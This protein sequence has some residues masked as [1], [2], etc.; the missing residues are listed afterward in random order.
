ML[1]VRT[2]FD[3]VLDPSQTALDRLREAEWLNLFR[4]IE[5]VD[6]EGVDCTPRVEETPQFSTGVLR[7]AQERGAD[8]IVAQAPDGRSSW[9]PDRRP[10]Q[11]GL[12]LRTQAPL[13]LLRFPQPRK[14]LGRRIQDLLTGPD[15]T[16]G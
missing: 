6:L 4:L 16:F 3:W 13:L 9:F 2:W 7:V 14:T 12:I 15:V 8:L 1:A 10:E 11:E 5:R